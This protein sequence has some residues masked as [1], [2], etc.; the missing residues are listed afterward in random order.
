VDDARSFLSEAGLDVDRLAPDIEGRFAS[1]FIRAR[2][3]DAQPCCGP[4]CCA[5]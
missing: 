3:V 4:D 5:K 1:A 2:K